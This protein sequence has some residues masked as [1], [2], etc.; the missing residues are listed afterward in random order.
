M[1]PPRW[2]ELYRHRDPT[3]EAHGVT[4]VIGV[5]AQVFESSSGKTAIFWLGEYRTVDVLDSVEQVLAI[6]AHGDATSIY[7]M[8]EARELTP[9]VDSPGCL[10][11]S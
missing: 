9:G 8:D 4:P 7:W 10:S 5:M 2:G 11:S 6:H 1:K 3:A